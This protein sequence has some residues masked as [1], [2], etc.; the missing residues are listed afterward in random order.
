MKT[1]VK[2]KTKSEIEE[3]VNQWQYSRRNISSDTLRDSFTR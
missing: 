2:T 1:Y 3:N